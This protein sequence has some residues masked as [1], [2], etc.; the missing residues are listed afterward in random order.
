MTFQYP[1][2]GS[3]PV[4]S[5]QAML[6]VTLRVFEQCL[7]PEAY[8][9]LRALFGN[10]S[11]GVVTEE[12]YRLLFHRLTKDCIESGAYQAAVVKITND[13][14][15]EHLRRET[16]ERVAAEQRRTQTSKT[17]ELYMRAFKLVLPSVKYEEL[18]ELIAVRQKR[19]ITKEE[20][21]R[22]YHDIVDVV[23][24]S[25]QFRE[26]VI[27]IREEARLADSF[28]LALSLDD[29]IEQDG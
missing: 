11:D 20:Y 24:P 6:E 23:V 15:V 12:E 5:D 1:A 18:C 3:T 27:R 14:S 13:M 21:D 19:A 16:A 10:A 26:A 28:N 9:E 17:A 4:P 22:K 29:A 7:Q 25:S 2:S 8:R